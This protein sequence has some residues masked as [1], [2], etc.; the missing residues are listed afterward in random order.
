MPAEMR[1]T[2]NEVAALY[3]Q[4]RNHY[5]GQLFEDLFAWTD[6]PARARVLEIG[7][8]TGIA[9]LPLAEHGC[10]ITAIELGAEMADIARAKLAGFPDVE[11]VTAP[12][13]TWEAPEEP[14]DLV[15]SATAI[16]WIDPGMRWKKPAA[17]LR[18][19]GHVAVLNYVHAEGGDRLFFDQVQRCYDMF[20]PAGKPS[21]N[22]P[23]GQEIAMSGYYDEP[24]VQ[25]YMTEESYDR[26]DYIRLISTYSNHRMLDEAARGQLFACIGSLIDNDYNGTIRK[27]YRNELIVARKK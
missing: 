19:G 16:H 21:N 14:Y 10:R 1:E 8:G 13:E 12:F 6:L 26:E 4:V 3:D 9:T 23:Y 11:I 17:L 18:R 24:R 5:P 25:A 2:F 22:N 20:M 15:V 27:C 7:A